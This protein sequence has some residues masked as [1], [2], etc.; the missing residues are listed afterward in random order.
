MERLFA[1]L[2][3]FRWL[4]VCYE[5]REENHLGFVLLGCVVILLRHL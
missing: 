3:N 5:R 1:W 2:S 4:V